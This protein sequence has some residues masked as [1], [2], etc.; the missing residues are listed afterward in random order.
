MIRQ[1]YRTAGDRDLQD[2]QRGKGELRRNILFVTMPVTAVVFV[3]VYLLSRS[4]F[5]ASLL[6]GVFFA[7]SLYSNVRFFRD[8]RRRARMKRDPR[9]V[10]VIEVDA[11]RVFEIEHLGSHGPAYCFF[12]ENEQALLLIGQ[13][14]LEVRE[15][16]ASAF[17]LHRW[18]DTGQPIRI[19]VTGKQLEP[20]HSTV[21]LRSTYRNGDIE[22]FR[23]KP[24]TLQNDLD[25]AFQK[26][27]VAE[28]S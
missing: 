16:P 19:E 14:L 6:S 3:L 4:T 18:S 5:E 24:E 2:M 27:H 9:A 12:V 8:S 22:V 25:S 1:Y 23:A 11:L 17:R 7:A 28:S 20:E 21:T 13:W 26:R 10:E 15:F